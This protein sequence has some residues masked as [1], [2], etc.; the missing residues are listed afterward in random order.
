MSE[1]YDMSCAELADAAAELALGVLTG[2]ERAE[3]LAHLD[4]CEACRE[5]VRQLTM[6]GEE[7]LGLLPPREP[8]AGFET[9]VME[10]LGLGVP[11][12]QPAGRIGPI[13][14][15]R[16]LFGK[17]AG[18]HAGGGAGGAKPGGLAAGTWLGGQPRRLLTAAAVL[19]AVIAAGLGG[20]G[21]RATTSP[22]AAWSP[23]SSAALVSTSDHTV[24]KLFY[25]D[26][27]PQ[28]VY[29]SVNMASGNGIV[30]C[31]LES[32]D[33]QVTTV[34]SFRLNNGFGSWATADTVSH[35]ELAGARLIATDGTVLATATLPAGTSLPAVVRAAVQAKLWARG[36]AIQQYHLPPICAVSTVS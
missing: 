22:A 14:R 11:E 33:G 3:A 23:L 26:G 7:L 13:S 4:H 24:G 36:K 34:G 20:W 32:T 18:S 12:R 19:L 21:L 31:E 30:I 27:N 16:R 1:G 5:H 8:P 10:R 6:T 17:H 29:M 35:G 9:R 25:Y 15:F 2:R 28:W